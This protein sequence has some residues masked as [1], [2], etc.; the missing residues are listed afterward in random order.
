MLAM[1]ESRSRKYLSNSYGT[2]VVENDAHLHYEVQRATYAEER[3]FRA[4]QTNQKSTL[5]AE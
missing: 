4:R 3:V 1:F 5:V 2:G